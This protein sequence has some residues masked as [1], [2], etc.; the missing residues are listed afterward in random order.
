[1]SAP[2]V[3]LVS[4][5]E[6]WNPATHQR[7]D[8]L[9]LALEI[10]GFDS[11]VPTA[12][13]T[14]RNPRMRPSELEGRRILIADRGRL[15]FDG[16][17]ENV[18]LGLVDDIITL[19]ATS[20]PPREEDLLGVLNTLATSLKVAPFWDPL[21]VPQGREED[22]AEILAARAAVVG[23]SRIQGAPRLCD[24]LGGSTVLTVKPRKGTVR[25]EPGERMARTYG[26]RLKASWK[27]LAS[28]TFDLRIRSE[29]TPSAF[30]RLE[31][32]TPEGLIEG[33]P[34]VGD[35]I[36]D[37]FTVTRS[38]CG[39]ADVASDGKPE[40]VSVF[41]AQHVA[42]EEELDPF[43]R[44]EVGTRT[45]SFPRH[46]LRARLGLEHRW[47]VE[48]NETAEFSFPVVA[49]TGSVSEDADIE[50][51]TLRS[52]TD[53]EAREAW[54]SGRAYAVGDE[55]VD[56]RFVYRCRV[57]HTAG[58]TRTG[59]EWVLV[60]ETS[61]LSSRRIA[62]FFRSERGQAVLAHSLERA[63]TRARFAARQV[64]VSFEAAMPKPW[65]ITEDMRVI[66]DAGPAPNQLP[67]GF[68]T[69]RLVEYRLTWDRGERLFSGVLACAVGTGA[70]TE[71]SLGQ[72]SGSAPSSSGRVEVVVEN[73]ADAQE[74][75]LEAA[76]TTD[77]EGVP[78]FALDELPETVIRITTTPAA[79][80]SF[81]QSVSLPV[82]GS[83]GFPIQAPLEV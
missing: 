23:H 80:T 38:E 39:Y 30:P 52:L 46:A 44:F 5:T 11:R 47:E 14:V 73:D 60:G 50:E 3:A 37:G 13:L 56:G 59:A 41:G 76:Q 7:R 48:R 61:Y 68:I 70:L 69:G 49:Q 33:F 83:L 66:L 16:V 51:L 74:A 22:W 1:M 32:Y 53:G 25:Y 67:G 9:P 78:R 4:D 72:V 27:E 10:A 12:S 15:L 36:G 20:R 71:P 65:T 18:P 28:Q 42:G 26:A 19:S 62:S 63:K 79:A 55:V 17:V 81:N 35:S 31:T 82:S 75:V 45:W 77:A 34:R 54:Q 8:L 6:L 2:F 21:C 40:P 29:G 58:Q 24:A 43:F 57:G 64:R